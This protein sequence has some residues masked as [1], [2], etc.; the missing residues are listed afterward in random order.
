MLLAEEI[1]QEA[2]LREPLLPTAR[3]CPDSKGL[4]DA[5]RRSR[6]KGCCIPS[7]T[8]SRKWD[9]SRAAM[10]ARSDGPPEDGRYQ[11][12]AHCSTGPGLRKAW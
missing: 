4:W 6:P 8:S 3:T 10:S 5:A 2:T 1:L 7:S 11:P 12:A 9:E